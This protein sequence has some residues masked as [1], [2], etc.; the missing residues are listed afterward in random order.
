MTQI[1]ITFR[2][3]TLPVLRMKEVQSTIDL[4][5]KKEA[6]L[7]ATKANVWTLKIVSK[8]VASLK[9]QLQVKMQ[10]AKAKTPGH[11]LSTLHSNSLAIISSVNRKK[12]WRLASRIMQKTQM[13]RQHILSNQRRKAREVIW[14]WRLKIVSIVASRR[15]RNTWKFLTAD[16]T[17]EMPS[18]SMGQTLTDK[19]FPQSVL[20]IL[21][22]LNFIGNYRLSQY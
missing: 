1:M 13:T 18:R 12:N 10:I 9:R 16:W 21:R 19:V 20:F 6:N 7:L 5:F 17:L 15:I 14:I 2:K 22:G 11:K 3:K 8:Q 4:K